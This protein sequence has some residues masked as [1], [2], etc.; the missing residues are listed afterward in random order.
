MLTFEESRV[1]G[2]LIEKEMTTP[3]SYPMTMNQLL[4]G[5]NQ[6]TN[7]EPITTF[8]EATVDAAM[9]GLRQ[10]KLAAMIHMA[11]SR[12]PKYKHI[13][14]DQYPSLRP[15]DMALLSV[16][17]QRGAQTAGE[18]RTRTERMHRFA[19]PELVEEHLQR[20]IR[21]GEGT[22]PL[23]MHFPPGGGRRVAAYAHL[24]CGEE[25]AQMPVAAVGPVATVVPPP[26]VA[27]DVVD[28]LRAEIAGLRETVEAL[29]ARLTALEELVTAP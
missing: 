7:R 11:G 18:L 9:T 24:F 19:S 14:L 21:H 4:T 20:L 28:G 8:D 12:A 3:D 16:L 10:K 2:C 15:S 27:P 23:V 13:V 6:T 17:M 25:A 22:D 26:R 5:C 1:L 29:T